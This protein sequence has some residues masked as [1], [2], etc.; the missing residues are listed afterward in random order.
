MID[1]KE[2]IMEMLKLKYCDAVLYVQYEK[3]SP[4]DEDSAMY[5]GFHY[6]N[7]VFNEHVNKDEYDKLDDFIKNAPGS[8]HIGIDIYKQSAFADNELNDSKVLH[9]KS[10]LKKEDIKK[11]NEYNIDVFLMTLHAMMKESL[12]AL[13]K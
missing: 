10:V 7:T 2:N 11:L 5:M 12:Y 13:L 4:E 3:T 9:V 6:V 1:S 8:V